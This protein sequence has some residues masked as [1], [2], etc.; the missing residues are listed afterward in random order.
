MF[1]PR[2]TFIETFNLD[3]NS[4]SIWFQKKIRHYKRKRKNYR[5]MLCTSAVSRVS[6]SAAAQSE[7]SWR[8]TNPPAYQFPA[9]SSKKVVSCSSHRFSSTQS[10]VKSKIVV[11]VTGQ[12]STN[13]PIFNTSAHLKTDQKKLKNVMNKCK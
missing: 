2:L 12:K 9:N 10:R 13:A 6:P 1:Y 5:G 7:L 3:N 4:T 8:F 11:D